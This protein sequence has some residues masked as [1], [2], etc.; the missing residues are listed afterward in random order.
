MA[1]EPMGNQ[2]QE[3]PKK[4]RTMISTGSASRGTTDRR[5]RPQWEAH[6][7]SYLSWLTSR[8]RVAA[9]L[10]DHDHEAC[11][12]L[13]QTE[14]NLYA[15]RAALEEPG[16]CL[17]EAWTGARIDAVYNHLHLVD[18]E[19]L[20]AESRTQL[21]SRKADVLAQVQR[22]LPCKD[23]RRTALDLRIRQNRL[24]LGDDDRGV[25]SVALLA[26][27]SV[28]DDAHRRLRIL[29][30][31][32][33][34]GLAVLTLLLGALILVGAAWPDAI[35]LCFTGDQ[36]PACPTRAG[37][38]SG[39]DTAIVLLVG[40]LGAAVTGVAA[41]RDGRGTGSPYRFPLLLLLLKLP[42]G[43]LTAWLGLVL[44][45]GGFVPGLS[46]LD[47]PGQIL[48]WAAVFGAG[49]QAVSR[50]V[51]RRA[52]EALEGTSGRPTEFSAADGRTPFRDNE[53]AQVT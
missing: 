50:F 47:T 44:V 23:P 3:K 34:V 26:A 12:V 32:L 20:R 46:Q 49:Q 8:H 29:R 27:F 31:G 9:E 28:C 15:A 14:E 51:D 2:Q 37:S 18:G 42:L 4:E 41:L 40:L 25:F 11:L 1:L 36:P 10:A 24:S 45:H 19:L 5:R 43:A 6:A 21:N 13:K 38:P 16:W 7:K 22:Y 48:A 33:T 17:R 53:P 35:S 30:N 39:G 52:Y